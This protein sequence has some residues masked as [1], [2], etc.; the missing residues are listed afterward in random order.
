MMKRNYVAVGL[1]AATVT[2]ATAQTT[3]GTPT[4]GAPMN[5]GTTT[6]DMTTTTTNGT[7]NVPPMVM[8]PHLDNKVY[9]SMVGV[10]RGTSDM[11]GRKAQ[12]ELKVGWAL[13]H[14]FLIL[15][16]QSRMM[17]KPDMKYEGMG[18]FGV[19]SQ[20][21]PKTWWFDSW[22]AD[23]V[24][25][26]SGSFGENIV[27][28]NTNNPKM[29]ETRSFEVKNHEMIMHAKGTMTWNGQTHPYDTTTVYKRVR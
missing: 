1:L 18:I 23:S 16:L 17:S 25:T 27:T 19:D 8:P 21:N 11:M 20:G 22:G 24:A 4:N 15:S 3:N 13:N 6:N 12:D 29:N 5:N 2:F 7:N 14:Q 9:D 26:G 28:I 10:W